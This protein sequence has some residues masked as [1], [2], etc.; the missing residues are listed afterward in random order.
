MR[1]IPIYRLRVKT[2]TYT[3]DSYG[4]FDFDGSEHKINEF[5][6]SQSGIIS[7]QDFATVLVHKEHRK[8]NFFNLVHLGFGEDT[9]ILS[10]LEKQ[11][12]ELEGFDEKKLRATNNFYEHFIWMNIKNYTKG[13]P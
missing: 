11:Y 4:L 10:R 12:G 6:L 5:D 1:F 3:R 2:L 8:K 7:R 9:V 13:Y